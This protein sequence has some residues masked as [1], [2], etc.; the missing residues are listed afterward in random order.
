MMVCVFI[1][2][3]ARL[4]ANASEIILQLKVLKTQYKNSTK[5][6]IFLIKKHT[7]NVILKS[8]KARFF[9]YED[10]EHLIAATF[11]DSRYK[12]NVQKLARIFPYSSIIHQIFSGH[13]LPNSLQRKGQY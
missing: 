5:S 3:C 10:N 4:P 9:K 7:I 13:K 12:N 6:K 8:M 2:T 11:L 1:H